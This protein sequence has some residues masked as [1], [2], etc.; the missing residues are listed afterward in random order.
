MI[1]MIFYELYCTLYLLHQYN[2]I[3]KAESQVVSLS[4]IFI[5]YI[6]PL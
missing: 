1:H 6:I 3:T 5:N 4:L 2:N